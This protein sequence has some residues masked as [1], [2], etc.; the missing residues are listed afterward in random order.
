[1]EEGAFPANGAARADQT[2]RNRQ[3]QQQQQL[4]GGQQLQQLQPQQ[5]TAKA[6]QPRKRGGGK[7]KSRWLKTKAAAMR[8]VGGGDGFS[9]MR[10]QNAMGSRQH[11]GSGMKRSFSWVYSTQPPCGYSSVS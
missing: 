2:H 8:D 9:R 4:R 3:H 10:H 6:L 5:H 7:R 11:F 1:M